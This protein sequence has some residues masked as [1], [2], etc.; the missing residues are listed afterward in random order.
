MR[1]YNLVQ[2]LLLLTLFFACLQGEVLAEDVSADSFHGSRTLVYTVDAS[3]LNSYID[4]GRPAFDLILRICAPEWLSYDLSGDGRDVRFQLSFQFSSGEDYCEK[5]GTLLG[6]QPNLLYDTEDYILLESHNT[7]EILNFLK[8]A[9]EERDC[10]YEKPM[11]AYF[12]QTKNEI[13]L[14]DDVYQAYD[15]VK[16][17]TL[18]AEIVRFDSMEIETWWKEDGAY[19]RTILLGLNTGE[20]DRQR[21]MSRLRKTGT[22]TEETGET[23]RIYTVTFSADSERALS[24]KTMECL[25]VATCL[26]G[27]YAPA[28]D[29]T[30]EAECREY[31]DL[32]TL[33]YD[34]SAFRYVFHF[35]AFAGN[36]TAEDSEVNSENGTLTASAVDEIAFSYRT[37]PFFSSVELHTDL[38]HWSGRIRKTVTL[39]MPLEGAAVVHETLFA[40]LKRSLI[41]GTTL[42]IYDEGGERIYRLSYEAYSQRQINQFSEAVFGQ[43]RGLERRISWIPF[44]ESSVKEYVSLQN[45]TG[46]MAPPLSVSVEYTLPELSPGKG[47]GGNGTENPTGRQF[48]YSRSDG[49]IISFVYRQLYLPLL[50]VEA[51]ALLLLLILTLRCVGKMK[52]RK[53]R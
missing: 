53:K 7:M 10:L 52:K 30:V 48:V 50:G 36:I 49:K 27:D 21:L 34:K 1:K 22:V 12:K 20:A 31:F 47:A 28:E 26:Y 38:S 37:P 41:N 16:V 17:R 15:R 18:D 24:Q 11:E 45:L 51:V 8:T 13:A 33:L 19:E 35:P 46:D 23:G 9:L 42:D 5:M 40:Q 29:G 43:S 25:N 2:I 32:D 4:G 14:G 6:Y 44:G 39:K 3:D